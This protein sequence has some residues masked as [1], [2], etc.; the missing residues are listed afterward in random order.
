VATATLKPLVNRVE[1]LAVLYQKQGGQLGREAQILLQETWFLREEKLTKL[2]KT[3]EGL[4][5]GFLLVFFAGSYF[6]F[7]AGMVLTLMV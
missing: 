7:L 3:G 5:L 6:C 4:K 2:Y 1:Q